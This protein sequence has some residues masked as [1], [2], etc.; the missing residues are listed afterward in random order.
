[1]LSSLVSLDH[2]IDF[3][4]RF[5]PELQDHVRTLPDAAAVAAWVDA[6]LQPLGPDPRRLVQ[7]GVAEFLRTTSLPPA[8]ATRVRAVFELES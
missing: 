1:M 7:A 4:T 8:D 3:A 5:L 2:R 6:R